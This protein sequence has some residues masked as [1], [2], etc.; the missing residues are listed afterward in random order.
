[1]AELN[2]FRYLSYLSNE[3]FRSAFFIL[4]LKNENSLDFFWFFFNP[5]YALGFRYE[6]QKTKKDKR[7]RKIF[8]QI[9]VDPMVQEKNRGSA[10]IWRCFDLE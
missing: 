6:S 3:K 2:K 9:I 4:A 8:W 10:C 1:M 5:Y 7:S